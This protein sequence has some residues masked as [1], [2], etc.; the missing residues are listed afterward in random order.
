ME[1]LKPPNSSGM[2]ETE[3]PDQ[4]VQ[5]EA[6]RSVRELFSEFT[7]SARIFRT[8]PRDNSMSIGSVDKLA[9]LFNA[10]LEKWAR[11]SCSWSEITSPSD[12]KPFS[13]TTTLDEASP[14]SSTVPAY[15]GWSFCRGSNA[16]RC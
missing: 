15:A 3:R 1:G 4:E 11:S 5:A 10:C 12:P 2:P 6:A 9:S 7:K 16:R 14:S 8:Y 13:K